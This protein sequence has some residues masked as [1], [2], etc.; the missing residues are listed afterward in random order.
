[1]PGLDFVAK[2]LTPATI[3][4][5]GDMNNFRVIWHCLLEV[6]QNALYKS[7]CG[8][9]LAS[10]WVLTSTIPTVFHT[11]YLWKVQLKYSSRVW[12]LKD[13][14]PSATMTQKSWWDSLLCELRRQTEVT[15]QHR[16]LYLFQLI[17]YW[18]EILKSSAWLSAKSVTINTINPWQLSVFQVRNWLLLP[19]HAGKAWLVYK[20][21]I[22][23]LNY[24][25]LKGW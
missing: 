3:F 4:S 9:H 14:Y 17:F 1:M 16:Y 25:K 7:T 24:I 11:I 15:A 23:G 20:M 8:F 21:G 2:D 10:T 19:F 22:V 18:D 5:S 13:W 6:L 12:L